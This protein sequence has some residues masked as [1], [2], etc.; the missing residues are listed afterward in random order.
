[1]TSDPVAPPVV[2]RQSPH[3]GLR[4]SARAAGARRG[5]GLPTATV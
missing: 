4:A 1:M 2:G 5:S 3:Q